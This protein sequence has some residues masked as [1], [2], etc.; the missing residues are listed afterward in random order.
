MH[1]RILSTI[2]GFFFCWYDRSSGNVC[3]EGDIEL[4][5]YLVVIG[6]IFGVILLICIG[7]VF[8]LNSA[9]PAYVSKKLTN[10]NMQSSIV[11]IE[12]GEKR[13]AIDSE[14]LMPLASTVKIVVAIEYAFQ[15]E[16][17]K[18]DPDELI[19]LSE[20]EVYYIPNLDGGAHEAWLEYV[21]EKDLNKDDFVSLREV[22]RGM[23]AFSS[24]ANTE[25]MM[26]KLGIENIEKRMQDFGIVKHT[27]LFYFTSS[28]F[29]PYELKK[30]EH[31]DESMEEAKSKIMQEMRM[32][33]EE[34]WIHLANF[35]HE[36]LKNNP[37]Y[38]LN[39][40]ITEW[41]D[42]D[43]DRI[44][45]ETFISSTTSEYARIMKMIN[46]KKFPTI[47]QKELEYVLGIMMENEANQEWLNRAGKKG[48]STQYILTDALF[49]E[50]KEGNKYELAI[51]FN[52]L[53]WYE[54]YKLMKSLNEF[55][56]KLLT[57]KSFRE[58]LIEKDF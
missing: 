41:W 46:D 42:T 52:D 21:K 30:R 18:L 9:S 3:I 29:I 38:K 19:K 48:G 58:E 39:A 47:A 14:K 32:M 5:K 1:K 50:D 26:D 25:Y 34:D 15:I 43:I 56:L 11:F 4:Y 54:A 51:F 35:I 16:E 22:A 6:I 57:D 37:D 31:P 2:E 13:L 8:W 49:A 33:E 23:I 55:E 53:K 20:L 12:N 24:N 45:S 10:K 17:D 27:S 7:F 40:N 44:F 36:E 28:L